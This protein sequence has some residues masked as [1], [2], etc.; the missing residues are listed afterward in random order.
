MTRSLFTLRKTLSLLLVIA[1]FV[2]AFTTFEVRPA[3]GTEEQ[4]Q[5]ETAPAQ[6]ELEE[7]EP[8]WTQ[9]PVEE[10]VDIAGLKAVPDFVALTPNTAQTFE[11]SGFDVDGNAMEIQQELIVWS[12]K[13]DSVPGIGTLIGGT[14]LAGDQPAAGVILAEYRGKTA[15]IRVIVEA[16]FKSM[17]APVADWKLVFEDFEDISDLRATGAQAKAN[18]LTQAA[19][20]EPVKYGSKSAKLEYDFL[21]MTGTS[22]AYIRFR[23]PQGADG[24]EIPGEPK[25]IGFWI[26]GEDKAHWIR[27]QVQ[28]ANNVQT[29]IDF[30]AASSVIN[31]WKYVMA[32]IPTVKYPLK[33]NFIYVVETGTKSAGKIYV[34]EVS[35]LYENTDLFALEWAN[36]VPMKIGESR[37][38]QVLATRSG[39]AEPQRVMSGLTYGSSN[40][41]VATVDANGKI[42][43][44]S[45]GETE[46]TAVFNQQYSTTYNLSVSVDTPIPTGLQ[47]EGP[48]SLVLTETGKLKAYA[49][50]A[51]GVPVDVTAETTFAAADAGNP[52]AQVNGNIVTAREI[53]QIDITATYRGQSSSYTLQVKSGELKSIEIRDVFSVI[54]GGT[55]L[56]AKLFGNYKVEGYKEILS[57]ATFASDNP[58]IAEVDAAT[59]E[60]RGIAPGTTTITAAYGNQ[61]AKQLVVVTNPV[62]PLKREMR[63]AWIS[64][65]ENIDWPTKGVFDPEQQRKD[66]VR[67]LD[68]L[69]ETG[70]NA[71]FT[72]VRPTSDSFYPSEYFP[73]S[74]WLTGQQGKAPS[75]GYDPLKFMIEEAHKRNM[76][77][78]AWINPYRISMNTDVGQ[79]DPG[80]PARVH[81]DWVV[82]N[83]GKLYFNPGIS[84]AKD[85]I[86][87]GVTEIVKNY[88]V[89]GIHMDDYFYPYP[90]TE[91]FN[92]AKQY[93]EYKSGGGTLSLGDWRRE[94]VNSIVKDL[95]DGV[96]ALK[97]YVKFGIS[98]FGIWRNKGSDPTGSETTGEQNYDGLYAD[99]RTWM[100]N[101]WVDYL[102][103]QIYWHFGYS[104]AAYEKL[105]DWWTKEING[106]NDNS[107]KHAIQ[108][109]IGQAAY[110]VGEDNN[111]KNPDQLPAQLRFNRDQGGQV[112]GSIM[113]STSHLLANP[114]GV[115]DTVRSMYDRPALIPVMPW[116]TGDALPATPEIVG[117]KRLQGATQ[118]GWKDSGG[119]PTYYAVYRVQGK[120]TP[121]LNDA[122]HLL[123][124]VRRVEGELQVYTDAS[125]TAGVEYTYAVTALNRLHQESGMSNT[126]SEPAAP[127]VKL[128]LGELKEMKSSQTQQVHV[129]GITSM[130]DK[131]KI[132]ANL[133]FSSS[134]KNVAGISGSGLIRAHA[135]GTTEITAEHA[136]LKASYTLTV[137][138]P[139]AA[140]DE[141]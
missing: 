108:L 132:S 51:D 91:A 97:P 39:Y 81:P 62:S 84:D 92:D 123:A 1:L 36:V 55:P 20:P 42:T 100:K 54:A 8:E 33:L 64:T 133:I 6:P 65:V 60:I 17:A 127:I 121:D 139:R 103:P 15:E 101:G 31:G 126:I 52:V 58:A 98:P 34:D 44:I 129:F 66:F 79:L 80:H 41:S 86:V 18:V 4:Q 120:G 116:L 9:P 75:D 136:G 119:K 109:Y 29:T 47:I 82:S 71:V 43:A 67:L 118:I 122:S 72:Q 69:A 112:S 14:L 74:H 125:A 138:K 49:V 21:G 104:A 53:G 11:V 95:H 111:W 110:R 128:E 93:N 106:Q 30:N 2:S 40:E 87:A 13:E 141:D 113:F 88:D 59:G 117:M 73:W 131:V 124:T 48:T 102:A 85:Y 50:F 26:Y 105:I 27:G 107:G 10:T 24:R 137:K 5:S 61:L 35:V 19:R 45:P 78:H 46:L 68:E 115:L 25:K 99:T 70:I 135:K 37:E 83:N 22:A 16:P 12:I 140:D 63:G 76:E 77:F 28:D 114:L 130:G 57:G 134:K 56:K 7:P 23:N 32:N 38:G 94:N 90:G 96:K 89:D 3:Y